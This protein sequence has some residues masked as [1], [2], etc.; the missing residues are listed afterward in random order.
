MNKFKSSLTLG[1]NL[2]LLVWGHLAKQEA[3]DPDPDQ[4]ES[5]IKLYSS[6][7]PIKK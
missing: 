2:L 1:I 4:T 6:I 3:F 5:R 7:S